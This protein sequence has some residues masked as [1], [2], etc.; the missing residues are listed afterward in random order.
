MSSDAIVLLREDH[1]QLREFEKA[2][3]DAAPRQPSVPRKSVP[4]V[5]AR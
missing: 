2:G 5:T 4:A 1:R 3:D